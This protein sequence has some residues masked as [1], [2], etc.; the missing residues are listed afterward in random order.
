M[1]DTQSYRST[2]I[3]AGILSVL[4]LAAVIWTLYLVFFWVPTE[5]TMGIVQ[6]IYYIHLPSALA[7]YL[8][9]GIVALCSLGYLWLKDDRLDAIS[10]SAAELGVV[11][12]TA[13]LI[14]G[15]LWARLSWGAWW[16]W[17]ARTTSTLLLW[18]I[19]VAYFVIRQSTENPDQGK[20]F[21]AILGIVGAVDI[22]IIHMSVQWFRTQH[23][24]PVVLRPEGPTADPEIWQTV[25]V[26]ILAFMLVFF[27]LLLYRYG[28]ER[29]RG[30]V[31][32]LR[33]RA[34]L[35]SSNSAGEAI[36]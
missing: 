29:M 31:E 28:L 10:V 2:R 4:A 26:G 34:S 32:A 27:A 11:F 25:L 23:P 20:R 14:Q 1:I 17:D 16:V 35:T 30:Q 18:M 22:P 33:Y 24:D 21:A 36:L 12:T 15:P 3:L 19:Y 5:R 7:A 13:V 6:R 8:A 9:F